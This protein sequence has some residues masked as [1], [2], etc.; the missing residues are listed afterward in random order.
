[1]LFQQ[2]A[3]FKLTGAYHAKALALTGAKLF[4]PSGKGRPMREWVQVP[5]AHASS[6][7]VL[8]AQAAAYVASGI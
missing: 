4:D 5:A 1:M 2:E 8:A 6:W 7:P 3:A